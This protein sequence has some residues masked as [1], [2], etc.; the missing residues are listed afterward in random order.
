MDLSVGIKGEFTLTVEHRHT[1]A[2]FG[3]GFLEVLAT[4]FMLAMMEQTCLESVE[5][6]LEEGQTTVGTRVEITHD[7]ATPVGHTVTAK[8]E[9]IDID[10]R[11]L[12][13]KV[14]AFDGDVRIGGGTHE[15]FIIDKEKFLAKV[16]AE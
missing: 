3:S 4:P 11:K 15:R 2:S 1:A 13:F 5:P 12:T 6:C 7:A 14:E 16:Y 9:I 8:S 10:R